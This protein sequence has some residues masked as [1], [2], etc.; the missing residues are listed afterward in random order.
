MHRSLARAVA[1]L[2]LFAAGLGA[3]AST[4]SAGTVTVTP[5]G[6]LTHGEAVEVT[7][8][9]YAGADYPD[10]MYAAQVAVVGGTVYANMATAQYVR[11]MASGGFTRSVT[12][13]QTF[14]ADATT[15]DC[16][17]TQ[18]EIAVWRAHGNPLP[19]GSAPQAAPP[20]WPI[21]G[22]QDIAFQTT[23]SVTVS[24]T[25]DLDPAGTTVTVDGTGF[26]P[27]V[28]PNGLYVGQVAW[29]GGIR[30]AGDA[31]WVT[32]AGAVG[33]KLNADGSF[34]ATVNA[35]GSGTFSA[36][37]GGAGEQVDCTDAATPCAIETWAAH[38]D[39]VPNWRSSTRLTFTGSGPG[40]G[41]GGAGGGAFGLAV[42]PTIGLSTAG[43]SSVT[44]VG[45]GYATSEPGIYLV[46]G[47]LAGRSDPGAYYGAAQ[48]LHVGGGNLSA[49]GSFTTA[50]PVAPTYTDAHGTVVN[51][52]VVQCY[53][54]TMRAHGA[55]DVNQDF[56][57]PVSFGATLATPA[58]DA[59]AAPASA[60]GAPGQG[61][62]APTTSA[63]SSGPAVAPRLGQL[64]V[65]RGGRASL[66]VSERSTVTFVLRKKVKGTWK[67]VKVVRVRAPGPG[68]VGTKLP[69]R[70]PGQ[71][72]ISIKAVS[73]ETGRA[74]RKV[75]KR[76]TVKAKQAKRG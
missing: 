47:P 22:A 35:V 37:P 55:T 51:C 10:G 58:P 31:Q 72:R 53:V 43:P 48:W 29:I 38:S 3:A 12:V 32:T 13:G 56:A 50:L 73:G 61:P 65:D 33:P 17:V 75:V 30:Y 69:I 66:S 68:T 54:Q 34:T 5:G 19:A 15:I 59:N 26:D 74:G 45:A 71:Y 57:V 46:Y 24:P 8:A 7:V 60:P 39:G 2:V 42:S 1:A 25:A 41:P 23:T 40:G 62:A 6:D 70:H 63:G 14:T 44:V 16:L 21:S 11:S 36:G 76:L 9:G 28:N 4:A 67:V 49:T 27:V 18:C 52:T 64:R 20:A